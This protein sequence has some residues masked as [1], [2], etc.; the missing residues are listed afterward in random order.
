MPTSLSKIIARVASKYV[1]AYCGNPLLAATASPTTQATPRYHRLPD[2]TWRHTGLWWGTPLYG[3]PSGA[4]RQVRQAG[5]T[6]RDVARYRS[7]G[8][9]GRRLYRPEW[10]Y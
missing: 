6:Q 4:E 5:S 3:P 2:G 8:C 10:R 1:H 9:R 7:R